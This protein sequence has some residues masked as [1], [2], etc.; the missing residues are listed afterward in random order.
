MSF[1]KSFKDLETEIIK[2]DIYYRCPNY[3]KGC[4]Q[5]EFWK[6]FDEIKKNVV[7]KI[8]KLRR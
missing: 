3:V 2:K 4:V 6:K 5:C 1:K 7:V 8:N